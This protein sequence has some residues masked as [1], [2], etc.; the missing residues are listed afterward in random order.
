MIIKCDYCNKEFYQKPSCFKK[1]K[2][3][4]CSK[5]C[6]DKI[7]GSCEVVC[8]NCGKIFKKGY[9]VKQKSNRHFCNIE[10]QKEFFKKQNTVLCVACGKEI[11]RQKCNAV[12]S[13]GIFYCNFYCKHEYYKK[14]NTVQ[15]VV[16]GRDFYKNS[17]ERKRYPVNCCSIKCRNEYNNKRLLLSC[18]NCGKEILL[19]P[20]LTKQK[21]NIFCSKYCHDKFMDQKILIKCLKCG[22][23]VFRS[24]VYVK[25]SRHHFCGMNCLAKYKFKESFVEKELEK[26]IKPLKLRYERNDRKVIGPLELDFYFQDILFAVEVNGSLHYKPIYGEE[27]LARQK[28]RD[29]RKKLMCK[30]LGIKL[31]TVKPGNCK[32]E[33]YLPRYKRVLW[34]IKKRK[35]QMLR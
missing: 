15:C 23:K 25:Q 11:K 21:K 29:R 24:P 31:R 5:K 3:H 4:C 30:K 20:S 10:C 22:K 13:H 35:K 18:D 33:T 28:V 2:T 6:A 14:I 27:T 1:N 19:P 9:S 34:E 16:C 7:K 17:S 26:L 12:K 8:N 32:R